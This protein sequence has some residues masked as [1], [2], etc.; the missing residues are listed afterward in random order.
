MRCSNGSTPASSFPQKLFA[1]LKA[2][3][4]PSDTVPGMMPKVLGVVVVDW[5]LVVAH[6]RSN[7]RDLSPPDGMMQRDAKSKMSG[8]SQRYGMERREV[9]DKN[10]VD[11]SGVE[12]DVFC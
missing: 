4:G 2:T 11:I 3:E 8:S 9:D 7:K 1:K 10:R 5:R 6:R 12:K